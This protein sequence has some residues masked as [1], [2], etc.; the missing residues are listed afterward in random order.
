MARATT[1]RHTADVS[2]RR[3]IA[4]HQVIPWWVWLLA[5]ALLIRFVQLAWPFLVV[6]AALALLVAAVT[7]SVKASRAMHRRACARQDTRAW[8]LAAE[9]LARRETLARQ[10]TAEDRAWLSAHGWAA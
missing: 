1:Q 10:L 3:V 6:V 5:I 9:E 4:V 7:S 8:R 2:T